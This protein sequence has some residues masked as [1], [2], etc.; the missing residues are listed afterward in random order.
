MSEIIRSSYLINTQDS[1]NKVYNVFIERY[2]YWLRDRENSAMPGAVGYLRLRA[3]WGRQGSVLRG[4]Q[5][6]EYLDYGGED[7]LAAITEVFD[8]LVN[9]KI[10]K[11]YHVVA[12]PGMPVVICQTNSVEIKMKLVEKPIEPNPFNIPERRL[13]F[14]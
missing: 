3:E 9:S 8:R 11:G 14:D 7:T 10:R 4:E 2:P 5:K 6:A 13:D 12:G 1:H